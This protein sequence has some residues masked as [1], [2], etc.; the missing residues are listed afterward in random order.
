[1]KIYAVSDLLPLKDGSGK[2]ISYTSVIFI[3]NVGTRLLYVDNYIF[4]GCLYKTD[5]Q[6]LSSTYSQGFEV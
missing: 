2:I 6:I 1:M 3:Q 4:N 5:G